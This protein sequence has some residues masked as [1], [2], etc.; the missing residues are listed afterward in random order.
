MNSVK[1]R[2]AVASA[3]VALLAAGTGLLLTAH[4]NAPAPATSASA[5]TSA[6]P[7][8]TSGA[9]LPTFAVPSGA[10]TTSAPAAGTA[11]T[12]TSTTSADPVAGGGGSVLPHTV[13]T[14]S[15]PS[16]ADKPVPTVTRPTPA[17]HRQP[18]PP[19][20]R[21]GPPPTTPATPTAAPTGTPTTPTSAPSATVTAAPSKSDDQ[22]PP[23]TMYGQPQD[24]DYQ[25]AICDQVDIDALSK[26]VGY[27]ML[28]VSST[29]GAATP[30]ATPAAA[31][32][33]STDGA[34]PA[35]DRTAPTGYCSLNNNTDVTST[36]PRA[37]VTA[38]VQ[39]VDSPYILTLTE[40]ST[41][42]NPTPGA[43][44]AYVSHYAQ[45]VYYFTWVDGAYAVTVATTQVPDAQ[46][47][48]AA[49][50]V[51]RGL[52]DWLARTAPTHP[53][54]PTADPQ[55]NSDHTATGTGAVVVAAGTGAA[56]LVAIPGV[57]LFRRRRRS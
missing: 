13:R 51:A 26:A 1:L 18:V 41:A 40:T 33:T 53:K 36:G 46:A 30:T 45:G 54:F 43:G 20:H 22:P 21:P 14:A 49:L 2:I 28:V 23:D 34:E 38:M 12:P 17:P 37:G 57:W 50:P 31:T 52:L 16:V 29:G 25:L 7:T 15:V 48:A 9:A 42:I 32:P 11:A 10:A 35:V 4:P 5:V 39:P 8:A 6:A 19:V 3:A 27:P 44:Q 56:G 55:V 47:Q 24:Y